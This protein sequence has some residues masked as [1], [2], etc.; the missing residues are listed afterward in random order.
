MLNKRVSEKVIWED[1]ISPD[2]EASLAS[3]P[4]QM[5]TQPQ[6]TFCYKCNNVIPSNSKYCPYCQTELYVVCPK[7]GEK[8]SSQYPSCSQCGTNRRE[9]LEFLRKEQERKKALEAERRRQAQIA[10][11]KRLDE[12]R[13]RKEKEEDIELK[14]SIERYRQQE[15]SKKQK[16]EYLKEN[17]EIMKTKEYELLYSL[18]LDGIEI[19][20]K[21]TSK[22]I[23][24]VSVLFLLGLVLSFVM[25]SSYISTI[26]AVVSFT[27]WIITLRFI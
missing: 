26:Y 3:S 9:Y 8:Y 14:K 7:C 22:K 27:V 12:E 16:E 2:N 21:S 13:I 17:A 5:H 19:F 11:R 4:S 24:I 6:M 10:E 25:P 15:A 18:F 20:D 23:R 1:S